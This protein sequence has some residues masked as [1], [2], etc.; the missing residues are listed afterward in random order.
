MLNY[1]IRMRF[2]KYFSVT[3]LP[4][5]FLIQSP[6]CSQDLKVIP[7]EKPKIIVGIVVSQMR[8]D[9]IQRYWDKLDENG[10][11]LLV[12][13]GTSCKN[14]GFNY[15]NSEQGVGH[16][17]LATGTT[18][19]DHGIVGTDWYLYLQDKIE[20]STEDQQQKAV[21]GDV[22]NGHYG[23]KNLMCTTFSDE[24]RISNN[25]KSKTFAISMDPAPGI[26][27]VGQT[28]NGAYWF[29][30]R[31][32][33]WIT[34]TYYT[35]TLP[36]WVNEFNDKRF[37][38]IYL[39]ETWSTVLPSDQYT[40]SLPDNNK[41][42]AGI[43][44]Q[45]T[46]PYILADLSGS[47]KNKFD[48]SMLEKV[49]YGNT[50]TKDF[51]STLVV[52]E[53]LGKDDFTDVLMICFTANEHIGSLFGPNSVEMEDVFLRLDKEI[54]QFLAFLDDYVG[55]ENALVFLTS[56]HGVAQV[57]AYLMD[58]RIPVGY[59]N[60]NGAISLLSSALN[61][62]YGKGD[63]IRNYHSGQIY[64][65]H[66][67]IEDSKISL[68]QMQDYIAQFMLQFSGVANTI[69]ANTLQTANFTDGIFKK[70]QNSFNQKRSGDVIINLKAG[71]VEKGEAVT[72][73]STAYSYDSHIPLIWYGWKIGRSSISRQVDITDI[74]PT[75][76]TFL[77]TTYPNSCTGKPIFEIIQ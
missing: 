4:S 31:T 38:D 9:Y 68:V 69:T 51:A 1:I 13:R 75:I 44:G 54:A 73:G 20:N 27:S 77:N 45:N 50:Y 74:A 63:W 60:Q 23:P 5:L 21:G 49:P 42:E 32:G 33:N 61:N 43:K 28:G 62:T 8:Y 41:Y 36:G 71:W 25:F 15:L 10:I 66:T 40:E 56:D 47:K 12:N 3:V 6:V 18:P 58:N 70:I 26:F 35:D 59:F 53:Q 30:K 65:N 11:K 17:S 22:D 14:A 29:D 7:P 67:L 16:A 37:P 55:K 39:K 34:S 48:Y 72:G 2:L 19:S 76:S 57:P 24:L 64:L 46:F 52:N